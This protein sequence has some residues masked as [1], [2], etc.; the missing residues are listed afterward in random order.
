M[1][2]VKS[3]HTWKENAATHTIARQNVKG[4]TGLRISFSARSSDFK[5]LPD[6]AKESPCFLF[7]VT[8]PRTKREELLAHLGV[9]NSPT[10]RL[11][12]IRRNAGESEDDMKKGMG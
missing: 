8:S 1:S 5:S 11:I 6:G 10:P 4:Q 12:W 9:A 3:K 7:Q 2:M